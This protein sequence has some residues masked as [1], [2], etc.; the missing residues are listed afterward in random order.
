MVDAAPPLEVRNV[1]PVP[2]VLELVAR[3]GRSRSASEPEVAPL[4]ELDQ[5]R[6]DLAGSDV[7][8]P[9]EGVGTLALAMLG[10]EG[11]PDRFRE[12]TLVGRKTQVR[13]IRLDDLPAELDVAHGGI[14][15]VP[16]VVEHVR[17]V[18][19]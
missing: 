3:E 13:P 10:V 19:Q 11:Q 9:P 6:E 17:H 18:E 2:V 14:D 7:G 1:R 8:L 12:L 4:R 5:R 16:Q 15:L